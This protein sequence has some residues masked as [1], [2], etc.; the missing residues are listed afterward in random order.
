MSV[1]R[2][3]VPQC[4]L[5][6]RRSNP[7]GVSTFSFPVK[8]PERCKQWIRAIKN[9]KYNENT[10]LEEL[11]NERVCS[12]HFKHEEIE[13]GEIRQ[14][15][16]GGPTPRAVLSKTAA[17]SINLEEVEVEAPPAKRSRTV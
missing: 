10:P 2:C 14:R 12:L 16:L 17:P 5:A 8:D 1:T 4:T 13:W 7:G 6:Q 11:R 9:P 15:L 3:A